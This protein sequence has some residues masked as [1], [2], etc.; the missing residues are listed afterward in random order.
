MSDVEIAEEVL[1]YW[2]GDDCHDPV[3]ANARAGLWFAGGPE[4]DR[5]ILER[6]GGAVDTAANGGFQRWREAAKT[7]LALILLLDQFPRNVYRGRAK[8]F[9]ND[10]R[11][12]TIARE[13][14]G[15]GY[16]DDLQPVEQ[17]FFLTPFMH[18]EDQSD[19]TFGIE[20]LEDCGARCPTD[21]SAKVQS[22]ISYAREHAAVIGRFG[23]FPHRNA[24]LGREATR[25]ELEFLAA[26][27]ATWGQ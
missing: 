9:A 3:Q 20:C 12:C 16:L 25:E 2:F 26:G 18:S 17:C 23:R 14:V 19:Q 5:E 10:A 21:W 8:A 4:V 7:C 22:T 15:R 11:V 13:G 24:I 1:D 27:A 6:F